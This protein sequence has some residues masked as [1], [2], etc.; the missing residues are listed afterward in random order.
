[1]NTPPPIDPDVPQLQ[2]DPSWALFDENSIRLASESF[3][4]P[5]ET[6]HNMS[7]L[8]NSLDASQSPQSA[9]GI[10]SQP[11]FGN[12]ETWN[13]YEHPPDAW[14]SNLLRLFGNAEFLP[15]SQV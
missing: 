15:P 3:L 4:K 10:Q 6:Q 5:I 2:F 9:P 11:G 7:K 13:G 1:M 12:E 8:Q 14:P